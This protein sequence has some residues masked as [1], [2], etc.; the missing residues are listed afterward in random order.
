MFTMLQ[1]RG[2]SVKIGINKIK[3]RRRVRRDIGSIQDLKES[4]RRRGLISP[5]TVTKRFELVAGFRRLQ[6]AKELGW[7]EIECTVVNP[8]NRLEKFEIEVDEN[9]VRKNFTPGELESIEELRRELGARGL[10][11]IFYAIKRFL[12]WIKSLFLRRE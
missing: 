10:M 4:M 5:I 12:R 9:L 1:R 3:V 7:S 6:A 11:R 8:A 2:E